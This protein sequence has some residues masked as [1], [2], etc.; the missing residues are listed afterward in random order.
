MKDLC[1]AG[2]AVVELAI[3]GSSKFPRGDNWVQIGR[4]GRA[5]EGQ[6]ANSN[7]E[8]ESSEAETMDHYLHSLSSKIPH[9][10]ENFFSVD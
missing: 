3:E 2:M 6:W 10:W 8:G 4:K 7:N 5:N 9:E 1:V